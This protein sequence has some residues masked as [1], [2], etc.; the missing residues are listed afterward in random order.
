MRKLFLAI[1]LYNK[2]PDLKAK[3]THMQVKDVEE[4]HHVKVR[5]KGFAATA[6]KWIYSRL[7]L[8]LAH[9]CSRR[10]SP[11][12]KMDTKIKLTIRV[13]RYIHCIHLLLQS[14]LTFVL[15]HA[16]FIHFKLLMTH[17]FQRGQIW[18][19][20]SE[21]QQQLGCLLKVNS[22]SVVVCVNCQVKTCQNNILPV[23]LWCSLS[24]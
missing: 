10:E 9:S 5:R 22:P 1:A 16:D 14:K 11:L 4:T 6:T 12:I 21:N 19:W 18:T 7:I 2:R 23:G 24:H 8:N 15:K 13:K 17:K 20:T 3:L